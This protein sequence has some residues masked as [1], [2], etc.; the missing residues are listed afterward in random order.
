ME[1]EPNFSGKTPTDAEVATAYNWYRENCELKQAKEWTLDY[2]VSIRTPKDKLSKVSSHK[3][4][5]FS[6]IGWISRMR[7]KGAVMA[8][9][10]MTF[11]N[12]KIDALIEKAETETLEAPET[13]PRTSVQDHINEQ[14]SN[15]IADLD[16]IIDKA[17]KIEMYQWLIDNNVKGIHARKIFDHYQPLKRELTGALS[18]DDPEINEFYAKVPEEHIQRDLETV[19]AII[20]NCYLVAQN[21]K[22]ARKPRA[23]KAKSAEKL[24]SKVKYLERDDK[25]KLQSVPV[26]NV[27]GCSQLWVFNN[28]TRKL[29]VYHADEGGSLSIKGTT[30]LG[31]D[32]KSSVQKKLRKPEKVLPE[33]VTGGRIALR[34][35][36]D[37][38]KAKTAPLSG[39]INSDTLLVRVI[40]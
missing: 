25:L 2:L 12:E 36:L 17:E 13:K 35:V 18:G 6:T 7:L 3:E 29:G 40:R 24:V 16:E 15:F 9:H 30:V 22:I 11:F 19:C 20:D 34:K 28:K 14:V 33:V 10:T 21:S 4:Q 1:S 38:V 31:F 37:N 27:I 5:Y 26:A 8:E 23:K 32:A 39:R